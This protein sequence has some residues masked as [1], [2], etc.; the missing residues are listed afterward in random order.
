VAYREVEMVE[1]R[2]V[3]RLWLKSGKVKPVA[4]QVGVDP[5]TARAWTQA[6]KAAGLRPG[7]PASEEVL[8]AVVAGLGH[9]GGRP[10]GG[11]WELCEQ[12]R[13]EIRKHLDEGV[14][15]TKVRKLLLRGGTDIPY[16]TLHRFAAE[17]LSFGRAAPTVPVADG[18][19][20]HELQVDTGWVLHLRGADGRR[21]RMKAWIFTP[22]V[23]RYRFVW[24]VE[25][26]TTQSAVEACEAAWDFYGGVFRVLLPDNTKAIVVKA[27]AL[28]ARIT[29]AFLEY[30]QARGFE[31]DP[32]RA[33]SPQDKGRVE[34]TVRFVRQDCFGGE[35]L[36]TLE[37]A[38]AHA[39]RWCEL[40]NGRRRHS[41]TQRLPRE[42]FDGVE[43]GALLPAPV[44]HYDVPL[45][46]EPKVGRDHF[47]QVDKALYTLPTEYIGRRLRARADRSLVRFWDGTRL[48]KTHP[49]QPPGGRSIDAGDFPAEKAAYALRDTAFLERQARSHGEAVG[50]FAHA[51]L[52]V[53]LP[54]TA[55]RR[56]Y[57][58]L[59]L[60][61]RYGDERVQETC[62]L[63]LAAE[64][65]DVRRL[66]RMLEL[67]APP[68]PE[69]SGARVIP[70]A[71][72]LR[73]GTQYALPL[74]APTPPDADAATDADA[75]GP[76]DER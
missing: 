18:K 11:T 13:A 72:H 76:E 23:S 64:M 54:W 68:A 55:M 5:K 75:A 71:R 32:A 26:E 22:A 30:A 56:V 16:A 37:E 9:G 52:D 1:I 15:L 34:R 4:R 20:G 27:D 12:H 43:R 38:R 24:P 3:L 70:L 67:A 19:P 17:E 29:P 47:A 21:R 40:D 42:H 49:R 2:E 57:A 45:W 66:A 36:R 69:P 62:A 14:V 7:E 35:Q 31:V 51:L 65:T 41:R 63:A 39:R 48:V 61:R 10:H 44:E 74:R 58:L 53:P 73:P 33:R 59:G 50:R 46:C 6:A 25:R 60:C 28:G 8:E